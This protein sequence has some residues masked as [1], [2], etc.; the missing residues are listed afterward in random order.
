MDTPPKSIRGNYSNAGRRDSAIYRNIRNSV[1]AVHAV[2]PIEATIS[3]TYGI[4]HGQKAVYLLNRTV[5]T[6]IAIQRVL[7]H[8]TN[9]V[10][11]TTKMA[12]DI[13]PPSSPPGQRVV[14]YQQNSGDAR[15]TVAVYN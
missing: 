15:F 10:I 14:A 3:A 6:S 4:S 7:L 9:M 2:D 13:I 5:R 12:Q 11:G 8:T 1:F